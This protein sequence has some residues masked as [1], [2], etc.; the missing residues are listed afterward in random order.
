MKAGSIGEIPPSTRSNPGASAA[1][2]CPVKL[3]ICPKAVQSG[4]NSRSQWDLL[5]G[6][7]QIITAS[8]MIRF[9]VYSCSFVRG[10][11][12][13]CFPVAVDRPNVYIGL[14]GTNT[15]GLTAF[16]KPGID[17]RADVLVA[18]PSRAPELVEIGKDCSGHLECAPDP[19]GFRI[20]SLDLDF[21]HPVCVI[22]YYGVKKLRSLHWKQQ[23]RELVIRQRPQG[24]LR[25][26]D[27][28]G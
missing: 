10:Q 9:L 15:Q 11:Q 25:K 19:P 12:A 6:S 23:K 26:P 22:S 7:F 24:I 14:A 21:A 2:A 17:Q 18:M 20:G 3:A 1:T 8:I 27:R 13:D 5:L 4:S 28:I 16:G